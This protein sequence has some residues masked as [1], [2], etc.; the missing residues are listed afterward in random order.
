M[1]L[2]AS[3]NIMVSAERYAALEKLEKDLPVIIAKAIADR[4]KD[5]LDALH[6]KR[7][8]EPEKYRKSVL[9]K[10]H[11]NKEEINA[12]RREA[13]RKKKEA[14]AAGGAGAPSS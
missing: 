2:D 8:A 6:A 10:Y 12:R 13:Y 1:S 9:E 7:K 5:K 11:K 14:A 4:E 3:G